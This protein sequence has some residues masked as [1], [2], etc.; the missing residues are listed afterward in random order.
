MS[1]NNS[2]LAPGSIPSICTVSKG[3]NSVPSFSQGPFMFVQFCTYGEV[4]TSAPGRILVHQPGARNP[5]NVI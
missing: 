2:G 5:L 1:S 4:V 3:I